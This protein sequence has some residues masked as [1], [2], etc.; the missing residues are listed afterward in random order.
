MSTPVPG[1]QN[2]TSN[3]GVPNGAHVPLQ[4]SAAPSHTG[5]AESLVGMASKSGAA[6]RRGDATADLRGGRLHRQVHRQ[7]GVGSDQCQLHAS[8]QG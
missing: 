2:Q 8:L 1:R 5:Q 3:E 7:H 4:V 6:G